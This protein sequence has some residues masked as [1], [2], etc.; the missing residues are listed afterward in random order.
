[1]YKNIVKK[2]KVE[3]KNLVAYQEGQVVSKTLVQNDYV[4]VTLFS[5]DKG[6]EISTH[7]S[8]GDA[9]VTVLE[10]TGKFT[11]GGDVFILKEGET[12]IMPKD[13]PHAVYGQEKFKMELVVSF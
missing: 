3:L 6:E 10:G 9:M 7:A 12:I 4:S 2:E 1:M 5:F 11:I 13:V 8:G